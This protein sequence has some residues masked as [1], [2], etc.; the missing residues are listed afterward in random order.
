M[1]NPAITISANGPVLP[2]ASLRVAARTRLVIGAI[3]FVLLLGGSLFFAKLAQQPSRFP[4]SN[5][6]VL[7]T[8]DYVNRE[9]LMRTIES[10]TGE[11]FYG[12]D[13]DDVRQSVESLPWIAQ[14]HVSRVWP[15]RIEVRV[16]EHEP[17]ARWNDNSLISKRL[18]VFEPPQ[19]QLD[20][21]Q[22]QEWREVFASL[23]LLRGA[24]GRQRVLLNQFRADESALTRFDVSLD[25]LHED[26]RLSQT[27]ELSN[28]VTVRLGYEERELRVQRFLDVYER[29]VNHA[30]SASEFRSLTF[31]MRY[32][33]G[34]A[35][36][37]ADQ[38]WVSGVVVDQSIRLV[39]GRVQ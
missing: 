37:G 12:L 22:Y 11:G 2:L 23:P 31:D 17:A 10:Y 32:S 7:G 29:L 14:A 9:K 38:E 33:N 19:L 18:E 1:S 26:E 36:G 5:V 20:N 35:L 28:G 25:L 34:F 6:D 15:G 16:E 30:D 13:I 39:L 8:V 4:V 21:P 27:L 24:E 3:G